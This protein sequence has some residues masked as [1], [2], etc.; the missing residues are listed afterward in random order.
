MAIVYKITFN[1]GEVKFAK[2]KVFASAIISEYLNTCQKM[3][4][5]EVLFGCGY[6]VEQNDA[7]DISIKTYQEALAVKPL[8]KSKIDVDGHNV[9]AL[10]ALDKLL[11]IAR[12]QNMIDE[13]VPDFGD[14]NQTM[15]FPYIRRADNQ[16]G[17]TCSGVGNK[18]M[19][20][21]N[22]GSL[23]RF[24]TAE[25]AKQFGKQFKDLIKD[26]FEDFG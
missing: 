9:N 2:D 12:M 14:K 19:S 11:T 6:K 25:R 26:L 13:F 22:I 20:S 7:K 24:K 8:L 16:I 23:F 4:E 21:V 5:D 3:T 17:L 15:F 18:G 1:N 10:L